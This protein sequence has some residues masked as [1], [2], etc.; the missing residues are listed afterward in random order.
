MR[1]HRVLRIIAVGLLVSGLLSTACSKKETGKVEFKNENDKIS[2]I[3]GTQVG[4]QFKNLKSEGYDL[5]LVVFNRGVKDALDSLKLALSDSQISLAME[6]FQKTMRVKQDEKM[7]KDMAGNLSQASSFLAGNAAKQGVITLPPDSLQYQVVKE[8]AGPQP[9][10]SDTVKLHY[11]GTF[12]NGTEFDSSR[13]H[14]E[15]KPLE[16]T[17]NQPGMIAGFS[18]IVPMMK[19]GSTW[20][21]F[22]PPKLAYGERGSRNIPPNSLLIFEIELLEIAKQTAKPAEKPTGKK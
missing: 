14:P 15:G 4:N 5:N 16:F 18:E 8:G 13:K 12:I 20:K 19:V 22:I 11:V 17:I 6:G 10:P 1:T 9:K 21:V 7:K 3:F 2:Y